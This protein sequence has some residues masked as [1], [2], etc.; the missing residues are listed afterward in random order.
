MY[1]SATPLPDL[2][3]SLT[4]S[5]PPSSCFPH[6]HSLLKLNTLVVATS[7]EKVTHSYVHV[8]IISPL[9]GYVKQSVSNG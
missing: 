8:G 6:N 9:M 2:S 1:Q 3:M 4:F 5:S 7:V